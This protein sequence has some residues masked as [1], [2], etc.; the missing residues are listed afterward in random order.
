MKNCYGS[1]LSLFP[2]MYIIVISFY[3]SLHSLNEEY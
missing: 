1:P 2:F 3:Q